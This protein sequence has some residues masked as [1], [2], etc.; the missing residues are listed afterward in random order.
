M[1]A[2]TDALTTLA[3]GVWTA[4]QLIVSPVGI[5]LSLLGLA[6]A[7][8]GLIEIELMDRSAAKPR[9]GRH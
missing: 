8:L 3:N 2:I 9:I 4:G 6:M 5:A 1:T 7:W